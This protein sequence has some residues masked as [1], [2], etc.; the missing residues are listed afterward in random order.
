VAEVFQA[1][2]GEVSREGSETLEEFLLVEQGDL[3]E[4]LRVEQGDLEEEVRSV[5]GKKQANHPWSMGV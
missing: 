3:E 2:K 5:T 1:L 4:V